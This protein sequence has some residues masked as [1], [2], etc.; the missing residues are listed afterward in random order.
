MGYLCNRSDL[1]RL[2]R[3]SRKGERNVETT[4]R[5]KDH[6]RLISLSLVDDVVLVVVV[7]VPC[8]LERAIT[9]R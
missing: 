6:A 3:K 7:V 9:T 2:K 5:G 8:M 4:D 1:M